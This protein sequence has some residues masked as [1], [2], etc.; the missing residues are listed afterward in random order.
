MNPAQFR[1]LLAGPKV[2]RLL[3]FFSARGYVAD[4]CSSGEDALEYMRASPRHVLLVELDLGDILLADLL[5][6]VKREN[7]AGAVI[8]LD[9]PA[10][11]GL[12]V[13]TLIRG[14]DG[15][16]ATPPDELYLFRLIERQLLAQWALAQSGQSVANDVDK[17]RA[18]KALVLERK[19]VTELVMEIASLRERVQ[20]LGGASLDDGEVEDADLDDDSSTFDPDAAATTGDVADDAENDDNDDVFEDE[21]DASVALAKPPPVRDAAT[22]PA[23]FNRPTKPNLAL[24]HAVA[25]PELDPDLED[26]SGI[27][28]TLERELA[29]ELAGELD[30]DS[31]DEVDDMSALETAPGQRPNTAPGFGDFGFDDVPL[32]RP[33]EPETAPVPRPAAEPSTQAMRPRT[34]GARPAAK[35]PPAKPSVDEPSASDLFLDVDG[36]DEDATHEIDPVAPSTAPTKRPERR[37]LLTPEDE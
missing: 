34:P 7:L 23:R 8:L 25:D 19:K 37:F 31:L 30:D 21:T 29:G 15:Y 33:S 4:A 24:P 36:D 27:S 12:I 13:A 26:D 22:K 18:E 10:K 1:L 28:A 3:P 32:T 14:V 20:Q 16:V 5:D 11:S 17:V 2:S 9:D 35:A 6:D